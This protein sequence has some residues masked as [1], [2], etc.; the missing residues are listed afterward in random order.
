MTFH[1]EFNNDFERIAVAGK[2]LLSKKLAPSIVGHVPRELS[3]YIWYALRYGAIVTAEVKDEHLGWSLLVQGRREILI[4]MSIVWDDPVKIKK[5]KRN[6]RNC[7]NR[8]LYRPKQ[9]NSKRNEGWCRWRRGGKLKRLFLYFFVLWWNT[10][11]E[12]RGKITSDDQ[13][14]AIIFF[15]GIN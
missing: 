12:I 13:N 11:N 9:R 10:S 8:G 3:W 15:I 2:T 7:P 1:R 14:F 4:G 6:N 5:N